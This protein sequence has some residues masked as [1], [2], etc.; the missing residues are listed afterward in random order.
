[1]DQ[2]LKKHREKTDTL[3]R[4]SSAKTPIE[5]RRRLFACGD[6]VFSDCK[7]LVG[8]RLRRHEALPRPFN[9]LD[10]PFLLRTSASLPTL[11]PQRSLHLQPCLSLWSNIPIRTDDQRSHA[12]LLEF[13]THA[14]SH[15]HSEVS[16]S[17]PDTGAEAIPE[18]YYRHSSTASFTF[19]TM[20]YQLIAIPLPGDR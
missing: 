6:Y 17:A 2:E 14:T 1:L 11:I 10:P 8:L 7:Q 3:W 15:I 4:P 5:L 9:L 16:R 18:D 19:A 13:R 12:A 20:V